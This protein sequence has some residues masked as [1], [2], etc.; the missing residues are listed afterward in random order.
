MFRKKILQ[1]C[2]CSDLLSSYLSNIVSIIGMTKKVRT[3]LKE[4][5]EKMGILLY[6]PS[7][8]V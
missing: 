8:K 5:G 3:A 4:A 2:S 6:A 1:S 7:C